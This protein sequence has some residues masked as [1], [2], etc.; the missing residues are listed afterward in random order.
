M[1]VGSRN[2]AAGGRWTLYSGYKR[3]LRPSYGGRS[4]MYAGYERLGYAFGTGGAVKAHPNSPDL[5]T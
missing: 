1:K 5:L 4:G 3:R 2:A